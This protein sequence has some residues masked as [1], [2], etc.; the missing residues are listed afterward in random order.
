MGR[1]AY[2]TEAGRAHE[3]E[4]ELSC[5]GYG[6]TWRTRELWHVRNMNHRKLLITV[7]L[8]TYYMRDDFGK[9]IKSNDV[10]ERVGVYIECK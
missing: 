3:T 9:P 7:L 1:K 6:M 10:D 8:K 5:S 2:D 4:V